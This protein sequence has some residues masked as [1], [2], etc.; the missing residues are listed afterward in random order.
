MN[1]MRPALCLSASVALAAAV[2]TAQTCPVAQ[3]TSPT[4]GSTLPAGAVTF[5]W[6]NANAD[7]FLTVE[8]VLGAHDIFFAFTGGAGPG[9]GV[10][11]ITLGPACAPSPPTGCIPTHGE[12]I[13]VT[14]FTLKHGAV[15]P[16][17]PFNY[18]FTAAN[19][20]PAPAATT[21]NVGDSSVLFSSAAQSVPLSATVSAA[22]PVNQGTVTF[23][24]QNGATDI[25]TAVASA[26]LT[27]GG[28]GVLYLLPAGTPPNKYTVQAAYS[29]GP[30]FQA[31]SG[32][33]T[34]TVN[35]ASPGAA[36]TTTAVDAQSV[37]FSSDAQNVTLTATVAAPSTVNEG[38]VLFQVVDAIGSRVGLAASSAALTSGIAS[39]SYALPAGLPAAGYTIQAAY[40]GGPN[41]QASAGT[42]ALTVTPAACT[43]TSTGLCLKGGRFR[44]TAAWQTATG[45]GVGTAVPLTADT[46]YFW[47]F[48]ANNVEMVIKVVDGR[49]VNGKFWV[50]AGGLTDVNVVITVTD[51]LTG[52]S[53]TYI[54]PLGS[55]FQ[56]IQDTTAF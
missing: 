28:A 30:A 13:F 5:E 46:G 53:R 44:V 41:F 14:L 52:A 21:T 23:Q 33:G 51:T 49:A 4:P 31:S 27:A 40:S 32:S 12:T 10:V 20:A 6:C 54:N 35:P 17:S 26:A 24:V 39:A 56:P 29:G 9:A 7:Y 55:A 16:P 43:A 34:L 48:S 8:S 22:S 3:L 45:S 15:V 36:P 2:A 25:G 50:F 18:T 37:A 42:G 19:T 47:F 11:S 1:R 38:T